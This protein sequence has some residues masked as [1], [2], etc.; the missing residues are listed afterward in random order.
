MQ[1][2]EQNLDEKRCNTYIT[3]IK[4]IKKKADISLFLVGKGKIRLSQEHQMAYWVSLSLH[5]HLN[6]II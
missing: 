2:E 5:Y 3:V 6:N 4:Y 1:G